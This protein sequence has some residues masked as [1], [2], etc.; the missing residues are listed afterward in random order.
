MPKVSIC[1]PTYNGSQTLRETF[2]SLISQITDD[3]EIVICDDRSKDDTFLIA[4]EY[5][6]KYPF[7]RALQNANNL[8]MDRNFTQT[9]A[10]ATGD[11]VWFSGQDDIF[12]PGAISKFFEITK[13]HPDVDLI[14][15]NYR[16]LNG[17]LSK[18][19]APPPLLLNSD[20]LFE[21]SAQ[22]FKELD[23]A[24]SFLAATVMRRE[25]WIRTPAEIFWGTHYVQVGIWLQNCLDKKTY[26]VASPKYISCRI[27]EDSWKNTGGQMLFEIFSGTLEVY[28]RVYK[29]ETGV[30]PVALIQKMRSQFIADL[31]NLIIFLGGKGFRLNDAL[32][33]RMKYIF[34]ENKALYFLYILPLIHLPQT[35]ATLVRYFHNQGLFRMPLRGMRWMVV[36]FGRLI[37]R[38]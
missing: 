16:F 37:S 3:A 10:H 30:V 32:A 23:Q 17:D 12:E 5:E 7:V 14:Y 8:G 21:N 22:Y 34:G 36:H 15:F 26:V 38:S 27:P 24:P 11:F 2:E 28:Y 19:V 35:I 25:F 9:V 31:P 20:M 33:H 13:S 29:A 6:G 1:I 18:E 4:K